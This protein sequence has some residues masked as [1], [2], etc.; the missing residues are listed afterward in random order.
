MASMRSHCK[1]D[2]LQHSKYR[3]VSE[4]QGLRTDDREHRQDRRKPSIQLEKGTSDRYSSAEPDREPYAAKRSTDVGAP[5][6]LPQAD[7]ST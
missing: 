7:S 6:S 2:G 3:R 1:S 5:R 4:P